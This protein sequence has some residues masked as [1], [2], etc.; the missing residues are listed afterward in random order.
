MN[1]SEV[2]QLMLEGYMI[3]ITRRMEYVQISLIV[4][5]FILYKTHMFLTVTSSN[6]VPT[7]TVLNFRHAS[8]ERDIQNMYCWA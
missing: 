8:D 3:A 4:P 1:V 7:Q 2:M 5:I 6:V